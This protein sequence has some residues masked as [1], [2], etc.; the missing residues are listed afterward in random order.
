MGDV[1]QEDRQLGDV[2]LAVIDEDKEEDETDEGGDQDEETEEESL[3][4][5]DTVHPGVGHHLPGGHREPVQLVV[6][7]EPDNRPINFNL[8]VKVFEIESFP[9][10]VKANEI[11]KRKM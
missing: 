8:A 1:R 6:S 11:Q 2:E 5:P 9:L 7:P 3:A 10:S 4:G